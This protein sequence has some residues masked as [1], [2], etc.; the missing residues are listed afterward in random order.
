MSMANPIH[1][2][3]MGYGDLDHGDLVYD[4]IDGPGEIVVWSR[5]RTMPDCVLCAAGRCT[6]RVISGPAYRVPHIIH[7]ILWQ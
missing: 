5:S 7:G 4:L 2:Y 6:Q 3:P 1:T